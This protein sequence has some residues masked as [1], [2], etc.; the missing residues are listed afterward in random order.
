MN[1]PERSVHDFKDLF[2][3]C[4]SEAGLTTRTLRLGILADTK[5]DLPENS[6]DSRRR[7]HTTTGQPSLP[8][9][10]TVAMV[11]RWL[12]GRD[13]VTVTE[14]ELLGAWRA[15]RAARTA[16]RSSGRGALGAP[17]VRLGRGEF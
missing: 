16:G 9:E 3:R 14:E 12:A 13:G 11:A 7:P 1:A 8:R 10:E 5:Q 2:E 15:D 17:P 6:I 4:L